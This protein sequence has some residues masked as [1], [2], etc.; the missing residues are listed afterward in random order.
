M[1]KDPSVYIHRIT[2]NPYFRGKGIVKII[3]EWSKHYATQNGKNFD[4]IE[5]IIDF[6]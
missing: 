3:K 4:K 2:T 6:Y 5:K 1:D